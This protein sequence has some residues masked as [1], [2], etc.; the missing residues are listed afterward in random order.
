[1]QRPSQQPGLEC[2][3]D[4]YPGQ[5]ADIQRLNDEINRHRNAVDKAPYA[6]ELLQVV[7]VLLACDAYDDRNLNCRLCRQFASLR[8]KAAHLIIAAARISG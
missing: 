7:D 4:L 2:P 3:I 6:Q 5:A 8:Q 1:M